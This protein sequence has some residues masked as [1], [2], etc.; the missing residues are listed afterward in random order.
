MTRTFEHLQTRDRMRNPLSHLA[1]SARDV[2]LLLATRF[3]RQE[4]AFES[5]AELPGDGYKTACEWYGALSVAAHTG[6]QQLLDSLV[7]KFDP[8]AGDFS[9]AMKSG[10]A[11]VDRYVFGIV[12]LAIY[13]QTR[14]E[15]HLRLGT[16]T[17]DVQQ[18]TNQTRSAVDDMFMMTALQLQAHRTTG[19]AGYLDFMARTML[20]YLLAQQDDGLFFHNA[21]EARVYWGRGNGWFAAGMAEMLGDLPWSSPHHRTIRSG[22]LRMMEALL[23]LQSAGGRWYQV[24]DMPDD[25]ENWEESSGSAMFTYAMAAGV[26][27]GILDAET[28]RPVVEA[29]WAGLRGALCERGDVSDVCTG[30]WYKKDAKEYMR[31][32]RLSGDGHGQAPVLWA[33]AELLR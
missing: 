19:D 1:A 33:A 6:H 5:V 29:A 16:E 12:P 3:S 31:L 30:S 23:P 11:H 15:R 10:T 26:R 8:L 9:A 25:P 4:L 13:V 2:G 32:E 14:D 20:D 18:T 7:A 28:Y 21:D 22:Y 24:L 27:R 17:A